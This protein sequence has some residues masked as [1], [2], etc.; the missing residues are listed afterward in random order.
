[1]RKEI[2]MRKKRKEKKEIDKKESKAVIFYK[3]LI[4]IEMTC[5]AQV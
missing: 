2:L 3:T 4:E 1:M 5:E